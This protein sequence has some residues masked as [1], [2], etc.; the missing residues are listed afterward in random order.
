[1]MP[2]IFVD[3][4]AWIALVNTRDS[5]HEKAKEVFDNLRRQSY[6]FVTTEFVLLEFANAL[7]APDFRVKAAIFVEGLQKLADIKIIPA[8]SELFRLG[9]E[10]YKK[11]SDKEWS[12]VDCTSFVVINEMKISEAFTEDRHFEQAG[13][14]KLL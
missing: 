8:S 11:R 3:S 1:M 13:F 5:L 4:V 9:F 10:L 14:V 2:K 6:Q 12:L 7:S